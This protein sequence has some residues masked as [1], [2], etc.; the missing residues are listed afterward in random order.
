MIAVNMW[1]RF[2]KIAA[3]LSAKIMPQTTAQM[4]AD[5]LSISLFV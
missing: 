2:Q 5:C 1:H 4:I 3:M